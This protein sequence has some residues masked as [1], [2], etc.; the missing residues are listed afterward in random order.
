MLANVFFVIIARVAKLFRLFLL[1]GFQL[2]RDGAPVELPS[3]KIESL[4]A[5]LALHPEEHAR[6]AL[7]AL[8]WGDS[9]DEQ[10]RGSL[11][12]AL[13][14]LRK[15]LGAEAILA[16]RETVQLNPAFSFWVDAREM[17]NWRLETGDSV[18]GLQSLVSLYRGDLL[19]DFYDDWIFPLRDEY[20]HAYLD[21]LLEGVAFYRAQSEYL[22]AI[23]WAHKILRTDRA[24][25]Q[26]HQHLM[27][28]HAAAGN[29]NAALEQ[30]ELCKRALW[31]E[32]SVEPSPE[33]RALYESLR[34]TPETVS[35][36]ARLTNL[37]RPTTSFVGR[38]REMAEIRAL[39]TADPN[40]SLV[41]L[42]GAGGSGKT[43]L[44][45]QVGRG[46]IDRYV[47]GV[48]WVDL[49]GLTNPALVPQQ[50]AKTLGVQ[51]QPNAPPEETLIEHLCAR[52]LALIVD[53]CEHLLDACARVVERIITECAD[54][55]VLTTSREPLNL[56]GEQVYPVP[57]L[58]LP[59][60]SAMQDGVASGE[61]RAHPDA[62]LEYE[63]VRVFV[64]RAR[65]HEP[66]F[67]L[68]G[69]NAPQVIRICRRL[70]GMP[71]A[72]ELAAARVRGMTVEQIA[73]RL[74]D[75][76][77]F[78]NRGHRTA[79]PRQQTLRAL[80]DWSYELLNEQ[81][82][83]LMARLAVFAGGWTTGSVEQICAGEALPR[84]MILEVLLRL[85]D[86]SL[87]L[88]E[89]QGD[90]NRY[91]FLE[92]IREYARERPEARADAG[93]FQERHLAYF[94]E[95]A[96]G[97]YRPVW[98]AQAASLEALEIE[99]DNLR[100]ALEF[101]LTVGNVEMTLKLSGALGTFW[102]FRGYTQEGDRWY[103][104]VLELAH[105]QGA[106]NLLARALSNAG[107]LKWAISEYAQAR[108]LHR[109]ALE[110]YREVNDLK[111][112]A[113]SLNNI[114]LQHLLM[115]EYEPATSLYEEG[116]EMARAAQ[117]PN[118]QILLVI[119]LG[120]TYY[121]LNQ[122]ARARQ[123]WE[124]ALDLARGVSSLYLPALATNLGRLEG[125]LGFPERG[126]AL[127]EEALVHL[128]R[129]YDPLGLAFAEREKGMMLSAMGDT[130]DGR[131]WVKRSLE[132][133]QKNGD[134]FE[135]ANALG[136]LG[137]L[138]AQ[139]GEHRRAAQLA[140][141]SSKQ[142]QRLGA[143]LRSSDQ[144]WY[145]TFV[146]QLRETLGETEFA[147]A[148]QEGEEMSRDEVMEWV[149]ET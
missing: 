29:R 112:M 15:Q 130:A 71:L 51:E 102:Y 137:R 107:T 84:E 128:E 115:G 40:S 74:D 148:W 21:A 139:L 138:E 126:L 85:V 114:A 141:F 86:K 91:R 122:R 27:F 8:F 131:R 129:A 87:V 19:Q 9:T 44:A 4:L 144:A 140:G 127:V 98:Q 92:T 64:E 34:L 117:E 20:R 7:A 100:A 39:L 55:T 119:N 120:D 136:Y 143:K 90:T 33:T 94:T 31:D 72:I 76:F 46:L 88:A 37:P 111:G 23:E 63:A 18:S 56:E 145:E 113:F 43:R 106:P 133:W 124:S 13:H 35:D 108:A 93:K 14:S 11:R 123:I 67:R 132:V 116:L 109:Q 30:Y 25:E 82:K 96:D 99:H 12:F 146:G 125:E 78:L 69:Q 83:S 3:R 65:L 110:L 48:W 95:L 70:D 57:S 26:A 24:N 17:N 66:S 52:R 49:T 77:T 75:R 68:N 10:A 50:V 22:S 5:Y 149:R 79:M 101:G 134:E 28:C 41:T 60:V 97:A 105:G 89:P 38:E 121:E 59:P 61:T 16:D 103:G 32:L 6:E 104:R 54:V 47:D 58:A 45:I 118:L 53:N 2:E 135:F 42:T 1:G 36:A 81:E 142:I 80:I 147:K 73:A 62:L